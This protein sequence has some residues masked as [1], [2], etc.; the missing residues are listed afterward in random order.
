MILD[1]ITSM[2]AAEERRV[3][4]LVSWTDLLYVPI[5]ISGVM[6]PFRQRVL[7]YIYRTARGGSRGLLKSAFIE[8]VSEPDDEDYLYLNLSL[9]IDMDWD[10]LDVLCDEILAGISQWSQDEWNEEQHKDFSRWIYFS[11]TPLRL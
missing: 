7:N 3:E 6:T 1:K 5:E 2:T 11:L 10:E 9:T 8:A 4:P